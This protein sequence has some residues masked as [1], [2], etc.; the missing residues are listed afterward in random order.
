MIS[1]SYSEIYNLLSGN[2]ESENSCPIRMGLSQEPDR[3]SLFLKS[4]ASLHGDICLIEYSTFREFLSCIKVAAI[5]RS[6]SDFLMQLNETK[7][8]HRLEEIASGIEMK[9]WNI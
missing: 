3:F 6:A 1:P 9:R 2:Y 5:L 4:S 8:A 7:R